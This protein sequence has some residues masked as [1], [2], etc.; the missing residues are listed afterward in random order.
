MSLD[1]AGPVQ[2]AQSGRRLEDG[3]PA[4][5]LV[6]D[7]ARG[8]GEGGLAV[9]VVLAAEVD[10]AGC[11]T[12]A[13]VAPAVGALPDGVEPVADGRLHRVARGVETEVERL[14][15]LDADLREP[16]VVARRVRD[17]RAGRE[18]PARLAVETDHVA[19][20]PHERAAVVGAGADRDAR[21]GDGQRPA[22]GRRLGDDAE[23]PGAVAGGD[24]EPVAVALDDDALG[25]GEPRDGLVAVGVV[26]ERR[27]VGSN[28]QPTSTQRKCHYI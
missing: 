15:A 10:A 21:L 20:R 25:P 7:D 1:L 3:E 24:S 8:K 28:R 9:R 19:A 16:A 11:G 6:D 4:V 14:A 22:R 13:E 27:V 26:D 2:T 23:P 18:P 12:D 5:A 17:A